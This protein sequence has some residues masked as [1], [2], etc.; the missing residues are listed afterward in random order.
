MHPF[1]E[2]TLHYGQ[3]LSHTVIS[4]I[5]FSLCL[6]SYRLVKNN[7]LNS[8]FAL[9]ATAICLGY[10]IFFEYTY[11]YAAFLPF[12]IFS[13]ICI[14]SGIFRCSHKPN[15]ENP[16]KGIIIG[17]LISSIGFSATLFFFEPSIMSNKEYTINT[18]STLIAGSILFFIDAMFF[19]FKKNKKPLILKQ[20]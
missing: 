17:R 7:L 13:M 4:G 19:Y 14:I 20:D 16:Y 6:I 9:C 11:F 2:L 8:F 5:C 10:Y 1:Y 15:N 3:F 12:L 18:D